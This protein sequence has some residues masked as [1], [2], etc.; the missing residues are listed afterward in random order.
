M[1]VPKFA[2]GWEL[3]SMLL[4]LSTSHFVALDFEM[5][6]IPSSQ[7]ANKDG[8]DPR[9]RRKP[10]LQQRYLDLKQAAEKYQILQVGI[11]IVNEDKHRSECSRDPTCLN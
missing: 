8:D 3:H 4:A 10:T 1:D 5:S 9:S 11:T 2:F 6:G 7:I